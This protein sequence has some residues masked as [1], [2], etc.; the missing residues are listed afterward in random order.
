MVLKSNQISSIVVI[1]VDHLNLNKILLLFHYKP[2]INIMFF[3]V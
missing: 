3:S 1:G 2:I